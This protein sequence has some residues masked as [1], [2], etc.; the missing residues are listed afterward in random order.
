MRKVQAVVREQRV[1]AVVE[2]LVLLGIRGLTL[3]PAKTYTQGEGRREVFRGSPYNVS[4]LPRVRLEWYGPDEQADAVVRAITLRGASDMIGD[5]GTVLV[6]YVEE[7]VRIRTGE[8]GPSA[9]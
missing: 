9:L 3:Y 6:L 7:A 5:D 4:F 1:D 2:R 8:R